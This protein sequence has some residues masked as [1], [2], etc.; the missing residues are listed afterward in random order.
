M[1]VPFP[2]ADVSGVTAYLRS[3]AKLDGR[4][5]PSS[6][7]V[8]LA[9]D[10]KTADTPEKRQR[11]AALFMAYFRLGG[12]QLQINY[13]SADD[14]LFNDLLNIVDSNETVKSILGVD[15]YEGTL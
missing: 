4:Y 10:R 2:G 3:A 12:V 6:V 15:L 9:L 11:L 13:L 1:L 8:N 14:I 5:L 7:V